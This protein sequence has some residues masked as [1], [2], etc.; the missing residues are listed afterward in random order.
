MFLAA[1][2][3]KQAKAERLAAYALCPSRDAS[4]PEHSPARAGMG[5]SMIVGYGTDVI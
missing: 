4:Q 1:K 2:L 3:F 5:P